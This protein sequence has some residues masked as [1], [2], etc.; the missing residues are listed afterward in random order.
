[1]SVAE[2]HKNPFRPSTVTYD[3]RMPDRGRGPGGGLIIT[4]RTAEPNEDTTR[5]NLNARVRMLIRVALDP[6]DAE[7]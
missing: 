3:P 5:A 4:G 6:T 1:M 7:I 2:P